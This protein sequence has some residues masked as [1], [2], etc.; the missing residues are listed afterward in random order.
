[1]S[2]SHSHARLG[3]Y[4]YDV[5]NETRCAAEDAGE[6]AA[7]LGS[8]PCR[9]RYS[10]GVVA[11]RELA[12]QSLLGYKASWTC[13]GLVVAGGALER[14]AGRNLANAEMA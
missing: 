12:R 11:E 8:C 6:L 5:L 10:S 2:S 14:R 7:G 3:S 4:G 9:L 1:M 13:T